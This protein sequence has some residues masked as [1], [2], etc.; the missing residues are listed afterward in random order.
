M[1]IILFV[2]SWIRFANIL[3]EFLYM[4]WWGILFCS[5][6]FRCLC[7]ALILGKYRLHRM[8]WEVF[9]PPL[10]DSCYFFFKYVV[11]FTSE[12]FWACVLYG[13]LFNTNSVISLIDFQMSDFLFL[14]ESV[15]VICVCIR[16]YAFHLSYLCCWHNIDHVFPL[17]YF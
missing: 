6:F 5:F 10:Q 7:L 15:V 13:K 8:S 14:L 11:E 2:C 3:L 12:A 17:W 4:C 9:F 16:I 1:Y